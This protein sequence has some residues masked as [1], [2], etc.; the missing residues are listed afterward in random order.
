VS[1]LK[2]LFVRALRN[3]SYGVNGSRRVILSKWLPVCADLLEVESGSR[4]LIRE[5]K[6]GDWAH[7]SL[8]QDYFRSASPGFCVGVEVTS[9][10]ALL[11]RAFQPSVLVRLFAEVADGACGGLLLEDKA[12]DTSMLSV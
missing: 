3:T 2:F 12:W 8:L 5:A 4:F 6:R 10:Q 9:I 11:K 1:G 7:P